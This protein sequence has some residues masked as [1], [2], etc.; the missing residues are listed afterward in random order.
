[1]RSAGSAG[2]HPRPARPPSVPPH[3]RS[4]TGARTPS[5]RT[6]PGVMVESGY[7]PPTTG[8]AVS[9][10][11]ASRLRGGA[12]REAALS[13]LEPGWNP[14]S[15][16]ASSKSLRRRSARCRSSLRVSIPLRGASSTPTASPTKK[17]RMAMRT[18][19]NMRCA[20]DVR[21]D[22]QDNRRSRARLM[23][24]GGAATRE[25]LA[26]AVLP[27][28][29]VEEPPVDAQLLRGAGP[30]ASGPLE[31]LE[32]QPPLERRHPPLEGA[33]RLSVLGS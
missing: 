11:D 1:M 23:P 4:R 17:N 28:L 31:R 5:I 14:L 26:Q 30:I 21:K 13:V 6:V 24:R 7:S 32:N 3:G 33:A 27:H 12:R 22:G 15:D 29:G 25:L 2:D 18:R 19:L 8:A 9:A 20:S 10:L 16:A